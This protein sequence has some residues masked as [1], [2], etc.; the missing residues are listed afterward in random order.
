VIADLIMM[1]HT[2]PTGSVAEAA[3]VAKK[4]NKKK[5]KEAEKVKTDKQK[6]FIAWTTFVDV[7]ID[8]TKPLQVLGNGT[9]NTTFL[10]SIKGVSPNGC[11]PSLF[12]TSAPLTESTATRINQKS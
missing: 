7:V 3:E 9:D 5:Q 10:Q 12:D 1:A 8:K 11:Q 2:N 6:K 4:E